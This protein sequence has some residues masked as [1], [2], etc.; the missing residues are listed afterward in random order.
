MS[1][2]TETDL[3]IT[4]KFEE[5]KLSILYTNPVETAKV[6]GEMAS[7]YLWCEITPNIPHV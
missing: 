7:S 1:K 2:M 5:K 4:M 6:L 3:N